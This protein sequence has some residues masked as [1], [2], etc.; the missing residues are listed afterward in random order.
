MSDEPIDLAASQ[1]SARDRARRARAHRMS[2][3]ERLAAMRHLL[4]QSRAIL[5]RHPD[6][7][8]HFLRRNFA[9]RSLGRTAGTHAHDA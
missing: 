2:P 6:G 4:E 7:L 8:A 9:A 3:A 1:F 5:E